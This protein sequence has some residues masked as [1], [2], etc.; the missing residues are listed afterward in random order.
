MKRKLLIYCSLIT[1]ALSVFS[2]PIY[3][4]PDLEDIEELSQADLPDYALDSYFYD[5]YDL[6]PYIES[7]GSQVINTGI[8]GYYNLKTNILFSNLKQN[9]SQLF[10]YLFGVTEDNKSYALAYDYSN[11]RSNYY[12][13]YGVIRSSQLNLDLYALQNIVFDK[14]DIYINGSLL[15]SFSSDIEFES[16]GPIYIFARN[17]IGQ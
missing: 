9:D 8:N 1:L 11:T 2:F 10:P 15:T 4:E 5:N 14:N 16:S 7:D 3:A 6:L 12:F 17:R 13:G